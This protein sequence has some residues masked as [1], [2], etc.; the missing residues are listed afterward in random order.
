M[1]EWKKNPDDDMTKEERCWFGILDIYNEYSQFIPC[2]KPEEGKPYDG[3]MYRGFRVNWSL[4]IAKGNSDSID[5]P[6]TYM[7]G[8]DGTSKE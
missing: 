4:D 5:I 1:D 8:S 2:V 7:K 3:E 6:D